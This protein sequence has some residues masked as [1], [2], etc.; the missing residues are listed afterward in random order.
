MF[1]ILNLLVWKF[2]VEFEIIWFFEFLKLFLFFIDLFILWLC[3]ILL[4]LLLLLKVIF[5]EFKVG[6][7]CLLG[8]DFIG[9]ILLF[10]LLC[11]LDLLGLSGSDEFCGGFIRILWRYLFFFVLDRFKLELWVLG[12]KL[13]LLFLLVFKFR[14]GI[15]SCEFIWFI[16][17]SVVCLVVFGLVK[18]GFIFDCVG[19]FIWR[20]EVFI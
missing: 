18:V 6:V 13:V 10:L 3:D 1:L 20:D 7:L 5:L 14:G 12:F 9:E 16:G 15:R 19:D 8:R 11:N 2:F 4:I 17:L